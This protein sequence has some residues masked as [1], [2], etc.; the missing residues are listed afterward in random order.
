M[1]AR[2]I[3]YFK[4]FA[5]YDKQQNYYI[6]NLKT[7][8]EH[9]YKYNE[10]NELIDDEYYDDDDVEKSIYDFKKH[11]DKYYFYI[12]LDK[13]QTIEDNDYN[14]TVNDVID[15][16]NFLMSNN[17]NCNDYYKSKFNKYILYILERERTEKTH[18][19][20]KFKEY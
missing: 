7:V 16:F 15:I 12:D 4:I 10:D 18:E 11:C 6:D 9:Y 20:N 13:K 8:F 3:N 2:I 19:E 14:H 1:T 5:K 17:F